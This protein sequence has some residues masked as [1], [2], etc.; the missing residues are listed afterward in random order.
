MSKI[1]KILTASL[2]LCAAVLTGSCHHK[3]FLYLEPDLM[4]R[5]YVRFDWSK[6]PQASPSSMGVYLYDEDGTTPLRF[7]F[8]NKDGGEIKAP[9]GVRHALFMNADNTSWISMR[10]GESVET[11]ELYTQDAH[12]LAAQGLA[13]AALPPGRDEASQRMAATPGMLWGGR[14]N[15][16]VIRPD[17]ADQTI[18]LYP[19]ELICYYTVDI[20][21]V[22]N[23]EGLKSSSIDA[24]ISG[25]ADGYSL[26]AVA[27]T[28]SMVTMPFVLTANDDEKS[29]HGDFLT[30]GECPDR[31][32][33][34][35][36]TVYT[37]LADGS[38]WCYTFDVTGQVSNAPD[39]RHV[40]IVVSGLPLPEPPAPGS[41]TTLS[42]DVNEWQVVHITL[43]M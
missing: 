26:G 38:R 40:H 7:I 13:S 6:A 32:E 27:P 14:S 3:E 39:P 5:L 35:T 28:D 43:P 2:A 16:H 17:L 23:L 33:A 11:M 42:P 37:I 29:L 20:L 36:L 9:A 30:F 34:H 41:G 19:E 8:D 10:H 15:N 18:T 21:D 31:D 4:S 25:M 24:T 1:H 22:D 12:V